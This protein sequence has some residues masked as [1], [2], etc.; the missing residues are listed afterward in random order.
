MRV[1]FV[2]QVPQPMKTIS[3]DQSKGRARS[4]QAD[5]DK[6]HH[7]GRFHLPR[8][9]HPEVGRECQVEGGDHHEEHR[10]EDLFSLGGEDFSG[11]E[12]GARCRQESDHGVEDH[13]HN[14]SE[15]A[16]CLVQRS[17]S[18]SAKSDFDVLKNKKSPSQSRPERRP[19]S[20][21]G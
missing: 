13:D 5:C 20:G 18:V 16:V 8:R 10:V 21:R 1:E 12:D 14:K 4:Y 2:Y 9:R 17:A 7:D 19:R 11:D 15:P 6:C 3:E